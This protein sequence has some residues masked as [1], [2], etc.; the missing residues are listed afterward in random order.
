[1]Q[2]ILVLDW[3]PGE[4]PELTVEITCGS[5]TYIRSIARDLG[6]AVGSVA[7]L[8][9]LVRTQSCNLF[10]ADAVDFAALTTGDFSLQSPLVALAHLPRLELGAEQQADWYKGKPIWWPDLPIGDQPLVV[11]GLLSEENTTQSL[12][13]IGFSKMSTNGSLLCPKVVLENL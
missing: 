8:V 3:Q 13:G 11:S 7:T 5:G 6:V 2:K 10:L 1:V 4:F 12:L 9:N